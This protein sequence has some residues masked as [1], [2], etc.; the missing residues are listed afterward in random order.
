MWHSAYKEIY[1]RKLKCN[2]CI[3]GAYNLIGKMRHVPKSQLNN[4]GSQHIMKTVSAR[5]D[6][7][8]GTS[9]KGKIRLAREN[10]LEKINRMNKW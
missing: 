3:L 10:I 6:W 8:F 2:C 5:D 7:C 4:S 9:E 1:R